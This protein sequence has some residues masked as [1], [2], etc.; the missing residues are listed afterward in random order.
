MTI[1]VLTASRARKLL[2]KSAQTNYSTAEDRANN[3]S[4]SA[5]WGDQPGRPP[6]TQL[7]GGSSRRE[8]Q[9]ELMLIVIAAIVIALGIAARFN[10]GQVFTRHVT[11]DIVA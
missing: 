11:R 2:L 10:P 7:P 3:G 6:A 9:S 5:S 4:G 8:I 1:K